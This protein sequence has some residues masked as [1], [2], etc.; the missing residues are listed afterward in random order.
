M[1][2]PALLAVLVL[3]LVGSLRPAS[4]ADRGP[5]QGKPAAG[6]PSAAAHRWAG[7]VLTAKNVSFTDVSGSWTVPTV[8]CA[9]GAPPSL[10]TVW[11]GLGGYQPKSNVLDQVGTDANCNRQGHATYYGWF[12]LLPDVA[13]PVDNRVAPGDAMYGAVSIVNTNLVE[14]TLH[15]ITRHW[16]FSR[17][18]QEGLPDLASAEW[19][20]EAPYSCLRFSCRQAPLA[21]F[22]SISITGISVTGS[23]RSG[24]LVTVG[25]L[26]TPLTL[27]SCGSKSGSRRAAIALPQEVSKDGTRF[28]IVWNRET[29][30]KSLCPNGT[31]GGF[32]EYTRG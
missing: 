22:G 16:T 12:E 1:T 13:H 30:R 18:I 10:S 29:G 32:S 5:E 11:V 2:P 14:L 31:V 21:N 27:A 8:K 9:P 26:R 23:G 17:N 20:V 25:W 7:Y 4:A 24:T 3:T 15:D 28:V 6:Q 19:I